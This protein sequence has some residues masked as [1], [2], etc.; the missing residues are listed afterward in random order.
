MPD[1]K[2]V[3]EAN[4]RM[5][6]RIWDKLDRVDGGK[7]ARLMAKGDYMATWKFVE[8]NFFGLE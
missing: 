5:S 1:I 7:L 3:F 2:E 4:S 8:A 6:N